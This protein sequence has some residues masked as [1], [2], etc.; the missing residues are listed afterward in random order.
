MKRLLNLTGFLILALAGK[1][2]DIRTISLASENN[3]PFYAKIS[4]R[5]LNSTSA[6]FLTISGLRDSTYEIAI[7]FPD[8][9]YPEQLFRVGV[10][11]YDID[12][13][14]K[15]LGE[16][17]WAL[18][19]IKTQ[20]LIS[21]SKNRAVSSQ[22]GGD[23]QQVKRTDAFA[24]MMA[25]VVNDTSVL[26]T[27]VSRAEPVSEI[28]KPVVID[29]SKTIV[30]KNESP[31]QTEKTSPPIVPVSDTKN[32]DQLNKS[33]ATQKALDSANEKKAADKLAAD[34]LAANKLAADK[35]ADDRAA[36]DK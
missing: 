12:F 16:P 20:N 9:R 30:T 22:N 33:V 10:N 19:D 28:K 17:G 1:T 14:L 5:T 13:N 29:S 15:N 21:S 27:S 4:G 32:N 7:G 26:Y 35:A 34:K 25:A 3:L 6:G 8:N 18:Q 11:K 36:A 2:Q 23:V 24:I 31:K